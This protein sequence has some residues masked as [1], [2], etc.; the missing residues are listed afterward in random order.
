[1][2]DIAFFR[3]ANRKTQPH[4]LELGQAQRAVNCRLQTGALAPFRGA[5]VIQAVSVPGVKTIHRFGD[6]AFWFEFADDV[7]VAEGPLPSDTETTTYFT[8]D[9]APA[10]TYAGLAT[11]GSA[12]YPSNKYRLGVPAPASAV[13]V[14]A[15]G[16]ADPDDATGESR[17]YTV[18]YVTA[19]GEEGPPAPASGLVE[20]FDGQSVNVTNI[21]TAPAGNYN[22]T[23]KRIYR[24]ASA[25]GDTEYL[26]VAEIGVATTSYSDTLPTE[27]LGEVL[28]SLD[29]N[30][31]PEDMQG[32]TALD[33]GVMAGFSGKEL[34]LSEAYLP[35]AWPYT[36]TMDQPIVGIVGIRGGVVVATMGQP[37]IVSFT[38]PAAASP[39]KIENPRACVSKRS[40][41]D[42]GDFAVYATADGLVA[43]DGAGNAPVITAGVL[44]TYQ[45]ARFNPETLHAYRLHDWYIGFYEGEDGDG[46]FAITARG[47]AFVELDFYAETG[48]SDP[49]DGGLYLVLDGNIVRW[50]DDAANTL[51][52]L[53]RSGEMLAEKP[54]NLAGARVDADS[55]PAT[56]DDSLVF[57]LYADEALVYEKQVTS[58]NPFAL[59]GNY[60]ARRFSVEVSGTRTAR[61]VLANASLDG[62]A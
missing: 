29:W 13:T 56:P 34:Y 18:T 7:D 31:P 37:V 33:G 28:P 17:V 2:F 51:E 49:N 41:V 40:M 30:P 47:D 20:V 52:Y 16:T 25:S 50:D 19:R 27:N 36:L 11:S 58:P 23:H 54:M 8:G 43:V 57:R 22:I 4:L 35:H 3:G 21:P 39:D 53:W 9:G 45:W 32:L 60:L 48:Y 42:M 46:G 5:T 6:T 44:D 62:L 14:A 15:T 61:R 12:P 10:M 1:M 55:Y 26:F 24:T 59:P 38:S